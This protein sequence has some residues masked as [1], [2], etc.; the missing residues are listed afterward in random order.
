MTAFATMQQQMRDQTRLILT[1][2]TLLF[3]GMSS[4]AAIA[5]DE[6]ALSGANAVALVEK[7]H[8][9][10]EH[11]MTNAQTLGAEGASDYIAAVVDDTYNLPALTAQSVGP[12]AFRGYG[13]EEKA[14]VVAAYRAFVVSNYLSRFGKPLPISFETVGHSEG[15]RGSTIVETQLVRQSGDPVQLVYVVAASKD[16]RS[17]IADVQ[18]NGVSEAARR[19]SELSSLARQGANVLADA[20]TKKAAQIAAD[21]E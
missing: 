4:G 11:L 20:L 14:V 12:S 21:A 18:Y 2:L 6:T 17:G 8:E 19:R 13:S 1:A 10:L 7:L 15:P 9:G 16:G 3:F 5:Q